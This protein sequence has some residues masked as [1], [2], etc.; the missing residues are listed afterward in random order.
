MTEHKL[1]YVMTDEEEDMYSLVEE[2]INICSSAK[3]KGLDKDS[4]KIILNMARAI[5][6]DIERITEM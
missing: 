1:K 2:I 4:V 5:K 3:N 6:K